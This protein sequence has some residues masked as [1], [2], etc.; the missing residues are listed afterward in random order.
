MRSTEA[1]IRILLVDDHPVVRAGIRE[2][3]EAAG[4]MQVV[5]ECE[6]GREAL[7]Q[8]DTLRPDVVLLD[9]E[10]PG[11]QGIEVARRL[12][13]DHP[14]AK[15]I[16]LSAH[17][18]G[19]FV[20]GS[21]EAG[22]RG[23]LLKEEAAE[24]ILEAVR[25]VHRGEDGWI[26]RSIAA[27]VVAWTRQGTPAAPDLT[28][29]ELEILRLVVDGMQNKEVAAALDISEKTVERHLSAVYSKL[30]VSSRVEAAVH[31]VRNDLV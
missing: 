20:R 30:N 4:D 28:A 21:L 14:G 13:E 10:M 7:E 3:L 8:M 16:A 23:Y 26:S 29:R 6:G 19:H 22:A 9:M 18:D 27:K 15:V 2:I 24:T 12:A 11:L 25:G 31:A 5:G 1:R 17:D